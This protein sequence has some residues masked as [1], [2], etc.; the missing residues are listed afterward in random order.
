M[1]TTLHRIDLRAGTARDLNVI[2]RIMH[3][4]FDPRY[5]EAWSLAQA[6]GMLIL[7]GIWLTIAAVDGEDAGFALARAVID[8]CE[9]LLIATRPAWQGCGVGGALLRSVIADAR[10][11][12]VTRL[13]LE[14][15][16]GNDA[17]RLYERHGFVKI[18]ERRDYYSGNNRQMFDAHTYT[19]TIEQE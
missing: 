3:D 17:V 18:G 14:V 19:R 9:L 12:G 5:G 13:H 4:A 15:R 10:A 1:S 11:R 16:A 6:G 2:D 7:P 8:D